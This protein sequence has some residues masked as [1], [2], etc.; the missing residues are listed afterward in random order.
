MT[1]LD[2]KEPDDQEI[3]SILL[4]QVDGTDTRTQTA[5]DPHLN[6]AG[7][8]KLEMLREAIYE[9]TQVAQ[10]SHHELQ[11]SDMRDSHR[12]HEPKLHSDSRYRLLRKVGQGGF[13]VV[14][15]AE[16][17][18]LKRQVAIKVPR[19]DLLLTSAAVQRLLREAQNVAKLDHPNIVPI[20]A[21]EETSTLPS[22]IFPFC[23][24]PNLEQWL[25][26]RNEKIPIKVAVLI[27]MRVCDGVYHAHTRGII[28]RDLKPSNVLLFPPSDGNI[29]NGFEEGDTKWIPKVTDFGVSKVLANQEGE[30]SLGMVVGTRAYMAPEQI[31]GKIALIGTHTDAYT[32]GLI[33]WELLCH[34]CES[35]AKYKSQIS[36][37]ATH[38]PLSARRFRPEVPQS[39]DAIVFKS[40]MH[41]P[42]Q[43]YSSV[44]EL[45]EDLARFL[46]GRPVSAKRFS[47]VERLRMWIRRQP[48][49]A[50]LVGLTS[51]VIALSLLITV[52]YVLKINQMVEKQ[53]AISNQLYGANNDL[54]LER[55]RAK[56][57][58]TY[59]KHQLFV[60]DIS[61]AMQSL[62]A[63]DLG[64]CEELLQKYVSHSTEED[65]RETAWW[66]LWNKLNRNHESIP[67]SKA[68]VYFIAF[69][70]DEKTA[71]MVGQDGYIRLYDY[72]TNQ[73]LKEW[74]AGQG[75]LNSIA[76]RE[77]DSLVAT[78]G[79]DG[80]ICLWNSQT[81]TLVRRIKSFEKPMHQACFYGPDWIVA[82]GRD[83]IIR[84]WNWKTGEHVADLTG[85]ERTIESIDVDEKN[86]KIYSASRDSTHRVWDMATLKLERTGAQA[87]EKVNGVLSL[88]D[89][90]HL[91]SCDQKG[92]V[93]REDTVAP[94]TVSLV[95]KLNEG[96]KSMA[97]S[98][99]R[100]NLAIGSQNGTI[101][102]VE[103]DDSG[104]PK[105]ASP[106]D[107]M[108]HQGR[109][110]KLSFS[111]DGCLH[112]VGEDGN[113]KRWQPNERS[114]HA[115]A[116]TAKL[117][118][119]N[120]VPAVSNA[121]FR[122]KPFFSQHCDA[123]LGWQMGTRNIYRLSKEKSVSRSYI[124]HAD[125]IFSCRIDGSI[126]AWQVDGMELKKLWR[127]E[128]TSGAD[129]GLLD[130]DSNQN[131][132]AVRMV[133]SAPS[134]RLLDAASG[135]EVRM[136]QFE[137]RFAKE[138][139]RHFELDAKHGR[140]AVAVSSVVYIGDLSDGTLTG[141]LTHPNGIQ[142]VQFTSDG[143][144]AYTGCDDNKIRKWSIDSG[145]LLSTMG[146][147]QHRI[148]A[149]QLSTDN[150][151]LI[152]FE[153]EKNLL[154][155][156][157]S[158]N[159]PLVALPCGESV[160]W[161]DI[162]WEDGWLIRAGRDSIMADCVGV[163]DES[164]RTNARPTEF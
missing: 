150:R 8:A 47:S 2:D 89:K 31:A 15:L 53:V 125:R 16:D 97:L 116:S 81:G 58:A 147:S 26:S 75:E 157:L 61:S 57:T 27:A 78:A 152:S 134:V 158:V 139:I 17:M 129:V 10:T 62:E 18:L 64:R 30:T 86:R 137:N 114:D 82:G 45:S 159:E 149:I 74:D 22:I 9:L 121:R 79:D 156:D 50:A 146:V 32:I 63:K 151:N 122:L 131:L 95:V 3:L 143:K 51:A 7:I 5:T 115:S 38:L 136:F 87:P 35:S 112:S 14:F 94:H 67:V 155:W 69:S 117:S 153:F 54:Q 80:C 100:R 76:F 49:I 13:G 99:D 102:V 39:L 163:S 29:Q 59:L 23:D 20:L 128:T 132:L 56:K 107:W 113:W 154:I 37:D 21:T 28:H 141:E 52:I 123:V 104:Y 162:I 43:R 1:N 96:A 65:M 36:V 133:S 68:A 85:H 103:L 6:E 55:D 71:G 93:W 44:H 142:G 12:P 11:F 144:T 164:L 101:C 126:H 140:F 130:F 33:L 145:E 120:D 34:G 135:K 108:T 92:N 4:Q 84:V 70:D 111:N 25:R 66:Y 91:F 98:P 110:H 77:S 73:L 160:G 127:L 119:I 148:E 40:T 90:L 106:N 48:A 109:L 24:G 105:R 138:K 41:G 42:E 124:V 88:A 83:P 19:P 46:E 72:E 118:Q 161:G 60:K